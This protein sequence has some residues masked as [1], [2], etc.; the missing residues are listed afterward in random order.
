MPTL[1]YSSDHTSFATNMYI[2]KVMIWG[3]YFAV[4]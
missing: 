4:S 3:L 1:E 2:Y